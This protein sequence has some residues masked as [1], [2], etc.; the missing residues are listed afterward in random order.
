[1]I[2]S[3]PLNCANLPTPFVSAPVPLPANVV[4]FREDMLYARTLLLPES[5]RRSD[6]PFAITAMPLS[7]REN[8][9]RTPTMSFDPGCP[10]FPASV[11]TTPDARS[12][13][14]RSA[15]CT[16]RRGFPSAT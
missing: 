11:V 4:T 12:M 9:A 6:V 14:R 16:A 13:R 5:P 1:M 3:T 15:P 7:V 8:V 10:V 2:P